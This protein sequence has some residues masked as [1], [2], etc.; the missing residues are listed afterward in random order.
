[1]EGK[2]TVASSDALLQASRRLDWRFL[3]PDPTLARVACIGQ[4]AGSLVPALELFST[5]VQLFTPATAATRHN[6]HGQYDVVTAND[7]TMQI[8]EQAVALLRPGG[9]LYIEVCGPLLS[10]KSSP[11][12]VIYRQWQRPGL[13]RPLDY[14]N[15]IQKLGLHTVEPFWFWPNF[16]ACTKIIPLR[17][18][19]AVLYALAPRQATGGAV[20]RW[21]MHGWRWLVQ[22]LYNSGLLEFIVPY[23]AIVAQSYSDSP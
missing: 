5:T 22:R 12:S 7:P 23:F 13:G 15:A 6:E 14:V 3:L 9:C 18:R 4:M 16:E 21:Q 8:L 20:E 11:W 1:M 19:G 17:N 10:F 2:A